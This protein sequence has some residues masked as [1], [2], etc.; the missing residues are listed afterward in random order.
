MGRSCPL[1]RAC[2]FETLRLDGEIRS[3]RKVRRDNLVPGYETAPNSAFKLKSGDYLHAFHYLHHSDPKYFEE[4][5]TFKPERFLVRNSGS[6]EVNQGTL[7]P[8][9]AGFSMCKGRII[10]ERICLYVV[11]GVLYNW[12]IKAVDAHW[13]VPGHISAAGVCKPNRDVRVKIFRRL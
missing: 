9:G 7:R 8:Y 12:E 5:E 10:A 1:L 3:I 4:P 11:A 2:Y 13:N 6:P